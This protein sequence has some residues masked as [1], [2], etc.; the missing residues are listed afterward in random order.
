MLAWY[1]AHPADSQLVDPDAEIRSVVADRPPEPIPP[2]TRSRN[3]PR[4]P[5]SNRLMV[6]FANRGVSLEAAK[7][8]SPDLYQPCA[9]VPRAPSRGRRCP[10]EHPSRFSHTVARSPHR[11]PPREPPTRS[12]ARP[13]L[14]LGYTPGTHPDGHSRVQDGIG[15]RTQSQSRGL[16]VPSRTPSYRPCFGLRN[17]RSQVRILSGASQRTPASAGVFLLVARDA[18]SGSSE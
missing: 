7:Q 12:V 3:A 18:A 17:R 11:L 2:E 16:L 10:L 1:A 5:E 15:A 6:V 14:G 13:R 8:S 9:S 4:R